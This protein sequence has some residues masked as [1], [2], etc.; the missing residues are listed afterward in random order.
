MIQIPITEGMITAAKLAEKRILA[1]F[2]G[3]DSNYTGLSEDQR[4]YFGTIGKLAV[5]RLL[6]DNGVKLKY[7]PE[8]GAGADDGDIIV[9]SGGYPCKVD[10]KTA[11]KVFHEHLWI[12]EKQFNRYTY[13]GY[14]GVRI[15]GDIAEIHGYC[16]KKDFVKSEHPGKKI[17][18]YGVA[19]ADLRP[20][21]KLIPKLDAGESIIK[22]PKEN[23]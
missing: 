4:F 5:V 23:A 10:V 22:I 14:I 11:S 6:H 9:Y 15:V 17:E 7:T 21:D 13:D 19:L 20:M 1:S 3:K 16:A 8:W 12:P 18:T 2:K